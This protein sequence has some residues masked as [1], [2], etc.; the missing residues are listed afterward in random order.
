M[1]KYEVE[2]E[3]LCDDGETVTVY[4]ESE[5]RAMCEASEMGYKPVSAEEPDPT[6][7]EQGEPPYGWADYVRTV[8][9]R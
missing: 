9:P 7:D 5:Y 2:Y 6:P 8:K 4:A 1:N 3:V